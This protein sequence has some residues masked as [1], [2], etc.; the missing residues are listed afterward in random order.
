M[1]VPPCGLIRAAA[2]GEDM[3]RLKRASAFNYRD[4]EPPPRG[5]RWMPIAL[6]VLGALVLLLAGILIGDRLGG[7]PA[8]ASAESPA[9]SPAAPAAEIEDVE[10]ADADPL[11]ECRSEIVSSVVTPTEDLAAVIREAGL[12]YSVIAPATPAGSAGSALQVR[13][14]YRL[15]CSMDTGIVSYRGGFRLSRGARAADFRR[16]RINMARN[17]IRMYS[18]S[19]EQQGYQGLTCDLDRAV[20]TDLGDGRERVDVP[21]LLTP[22]GVVGLNVGLGI[23]SFRPG[24]TIANLRMTTRRLA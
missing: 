19:V 23:D 14:N 15:S 8:S 17:L 2:I 11:P 3:D 6:G 24:D 13:S 9:S 18:T 5:A 12:E 4:E 21:L 16:L 1:M 7:E 10:L 20:V 22:E